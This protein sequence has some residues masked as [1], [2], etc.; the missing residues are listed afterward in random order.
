MKE[1]GGL[2][3][4]PVF[5]ANIELQLT[6]DS[7]YRLIKMVSKENYTAKMGPINAKSSGILTNTFTYDGN[8]AIPT[9]G[10]NS[11]L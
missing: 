2:S 3:G 10:E 7:N 4:Y 11:S 9:V 1:T 6:I 5:N 8:F